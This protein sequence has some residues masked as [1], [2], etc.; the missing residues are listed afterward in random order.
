MSNSISL[1]GGRQNQPDLVRMLRAASVC[2]AWAQRL[3]VLRLGV[4][5]TLA[6]SGAVAAFASAAATPVTILG[7]L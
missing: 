1:L 7:G 3:D 4:S 2:H 5:L 6:A